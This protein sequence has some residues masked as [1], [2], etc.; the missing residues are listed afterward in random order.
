MVVSERAGQ[1]LG[2]E[3]LE[4]IGDRKDFG[5]RMEVVRGEILKVASTEPEGT[6]LDSLE[7][8]DVGGECVRKPN[9]GSIGKNRTDE[10]FVCSEHCLIL[11]SPGCPRVYTRIKQSTY[12]GTSIKLSI[13]SSL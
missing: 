9:R 13:Y 6:V 11:V 3:E 12:I 7:F 4:V 1:E 2:T 5:F 10:G 8:V